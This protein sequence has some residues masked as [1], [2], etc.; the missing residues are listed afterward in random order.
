M[1]PRYTIVFYGVPYSIYIDLR[2]DLTEQLQ[3]RGVAHTDLPLFVSLPADYTSIEIVWII[4]P[5]Q[6]ATISIDESIK[7][8]LAELK[9][10]AV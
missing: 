9:N 6:D 5:D 1:K 2:K 7:R 3:D 10:C 8:S 4:E